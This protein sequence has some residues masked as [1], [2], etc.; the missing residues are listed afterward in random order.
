MNIGG[1]VKRGAKWKYCGQWGVTTKYT[2]DFIDGI[3]DG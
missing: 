3:L 2:M 1:Q